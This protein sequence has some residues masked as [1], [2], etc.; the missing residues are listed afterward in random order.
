[1]VGIVMCATNRIDKLIL[2]NCN[3]RSG[4]VPILGDKH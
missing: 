1:M 2:N 3:S 4:F